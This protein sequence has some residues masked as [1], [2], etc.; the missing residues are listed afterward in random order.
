[1]LK[2][3]QK[4]AERCSLVN[5]TNIYCPWHKHLYIKQLIPNLKQRVQCERCYRTCRCWCVLL[6][7]CIWLKSDECLWEGSCISLNW[8]K[9]WSRGGTGSCWTILVLIKRSG[10]NINLICS[11]QMWDREV[12]VSTRRGEKNYKLHNKLLEMTVLLILSWYQNAAMVS[13]SA[14][15]AFFP[16]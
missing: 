16:E 5:D 4:T 3:W 1:M 7:P 11:R 2:I 15:L 8:R 9:Q 13:K 10:P 6:C 12:M 14:P